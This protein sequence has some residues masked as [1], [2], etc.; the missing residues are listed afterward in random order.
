MSSQ[1]HQDKGINKRLT[2]LEEK[3]GFSKKKN[4]YFSTNTFGME[5][6]IL[7][8]ENQSTALFSFMREF[9][10]NSRDFAK[11]AL[12][13][14]KAHQKSMQLLVKRLVQFQRNQR[15]VKI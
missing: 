2:N 5:E 10:E 4:L 12:E 7:A 11:K 1:S 8:L 6:E 15:K 3:N 14:I 9:G 13:M